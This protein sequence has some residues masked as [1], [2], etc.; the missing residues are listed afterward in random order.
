MEYTSWYGICCGSP[1]TRDCQPSYSR[2]KV[3]MWPAERPCFYELPHGHT[4]ARPL[5]PH[6][7]RLSDDHAGMQHGHLGESQLPLLRPTVGEPCAVDILGTEN[8]LQ[9][10]PTSKR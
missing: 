3:F 5:P 7:P 1:H 10:W 4:E 6:S 9:H 2:E 8:L